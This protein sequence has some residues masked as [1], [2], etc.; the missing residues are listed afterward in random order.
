MKY[1]KGWQTNSW[2]A[3]AWGG[4]LAAIVAAGKRIPALMPKWF[5]DGLT[6]IRGK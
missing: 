6:T 2:Y 3:P 5:R 1:F 4:V